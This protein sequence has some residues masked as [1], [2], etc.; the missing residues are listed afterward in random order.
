M[1]ELQNMR[2]TATKVVAQVLDNYKKREETAISNDITE[3]YV[4][5]ISKEVAR[6][7]FKIA[8]VGGKLAK[9]WE[10][11]VFGSSH[12]E[13]NNV[14]VEITHCTWDAQTDAFLKEHHTIIYVLDRADQVPQVRSLCFIL[15]SLDSKYCRYCAHIRCYCTVQ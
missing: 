7:W 2:D 14:K 5:F 9:E 3:V 11:L 12:N 15:I 10:E 8:I 13:W 1:T 6:A 4:N